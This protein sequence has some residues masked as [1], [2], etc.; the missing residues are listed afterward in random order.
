MKQRIVITGETRFDIKADTNRDINR[1]V[2]SAV[3]SKRYKDLENLIFEEFILDG[4]N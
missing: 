2:F 1:F 3:S 4:Q